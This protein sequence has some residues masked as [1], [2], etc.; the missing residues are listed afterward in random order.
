MAQLYSLSTVFPDFNVSVLISDFESGHQGRQRKVRRQGEVV[1]SP[2]LQRA[3]QVP[4]S[5]QC[6]RRSQLTTGANIVEF[7]VRDLHR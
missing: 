4:P 6:L 1:P 7:Y 5:H 3:Q 2:R